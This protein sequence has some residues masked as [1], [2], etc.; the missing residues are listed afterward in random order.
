MKIFEFLI[1]LEDLIVIEV[2]EYSPIQKYFFMNVGWHL[3]IISLNEFDY[4]V[5]ALLILNVFK[6]LGYEEV[7]NIIRVI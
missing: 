5:K 3:F 7:K 2:N 1:V 6:N 4:F